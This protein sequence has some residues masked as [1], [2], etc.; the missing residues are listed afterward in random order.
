MNTRKINRTL[1]RAIDILQL[2]KSNNNA[3]TIKEISRL[4]Q[5]PTSSAFDIIHTLQAEKFL[6]CNGSGAKT[7]SIGVRAFEIGVAYHQHTN[8][9]K[10]I[11]PYVEKLMQISNSTSFLAIVDDIEI[12]YLDKS[13]AETSVRTSAIL[14]SR[15]DMYS[16]G[17]G[18]A[19]MMHY[20]E[21]KIRSIL[22]TRK[23]I[24][25]TEYTITDVDR[26][27]EEM[28]ISRHHG[29]AVDDRESNINVFCIAHAIFDSYGNPFGA[30]SIATMYSAID[31]LSVRKFGK[32][33]SDY[34]LEISK[35][36]GYLVP[37]GKNEK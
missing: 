6:E 26:F 21:K 29:Y 5:I 30:I 24:A 32:I 4:M 25:H 13:E 37:P 20:T 7:F 1:K 19:I 3:L 12:I 28:E 22:A 36:L 23:L 35:K 34:A 33:I 17:L 27:L 9:I 2:I 16:T 15:R 8:L 18:K 10:L 14:G 31:E 11:H